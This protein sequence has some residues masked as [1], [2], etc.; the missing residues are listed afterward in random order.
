MTHTK[1][2]DSVNCNLASRKLYD[3]RNRDS[4]RARTV[5]D[6]YEQLASAVM[7]QA[8]ADLSSPDQALDAL[9]WLASPIAGTFCEALEIDG[10]P[11]QPVTVGGGKL[12]KQHKETKA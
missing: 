6:P 10:D 12:F 11:L 2:M 5:G 7:L 8:Y 1:K 4:R 9:Y 3:L